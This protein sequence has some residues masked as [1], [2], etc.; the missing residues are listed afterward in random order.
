MVRDEI[1]RV[2]VSSEAEELSEDAR[3]LVALE[4]PAASYSPAPSL[5]MSMVTLASP[6]LFSGSV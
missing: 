3:D 4:R 2:A 5:S 1:E 6:A